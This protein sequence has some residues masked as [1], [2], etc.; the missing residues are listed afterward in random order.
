MSIILKWIYNLKVIPVKI[1]AGT[2][3]KS[4]KM[5]L[6]CVWKS[7]GTRIAKIILKKKLKNIH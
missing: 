6:K 2:V 3:I 7:K 4:Q 1:L 5:V